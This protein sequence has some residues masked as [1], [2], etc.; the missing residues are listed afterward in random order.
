MPELPEV[1]TVRRSLLPHL[2][3]RTVVGVN[4]RRIRLREG[5][6][7][8]GWK[9]LPGKRVDA[10]ERRGKY[11][12][13]LLGDRAAL[14]HLGMSGRLV[15]SPCGA[16]VDPHTHVRVIF[17]PPLELRFVDPR[18]FGVAVTLAASRLAR[19]P[20]LAALGPDVLLD[21]FEP[22]LRVGAARSRVAI[23][24]LLLDQGVI[25]GLGNI[26][27]NEAL[28]RAGIRPERPASAIS[29]PRL[30]RLA[31]AIREVIAD[32]LADGGTTLDDEGFSDATGASGY[33]AVRLEV[34]GREGQPCRRCG[35]AIIR[36]TLTARS[37]YFCPRC[38]R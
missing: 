29:T 31:C 2:L 23:R 10:L 25:A 13:A 12:Y 14:F 20:G 17:A 26:Y 16:P 4:V 33:F 19:H 38:Q 6:V 28:A 21:D 5:V 34:Y 9:I 18:R 37:A 15:L 8:A 24:N 22:A 30:T 35:G 1:E 32:A 7:G 36:H 27:A 3:G 11:L